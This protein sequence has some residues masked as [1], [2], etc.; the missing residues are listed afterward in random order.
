[1]SRY[2]IATGWWC[3]DDRDDRDCRKGDEIIRSREFHALWHECVTKYANA[4]EILVIDSASPIKP[5]KFPGEVWLEMKTN[6]GHATRCVEKLSGVSRAFLMSMMYC[7]LNEY[8]Y[9]V[10]VEQD[11]LIYG[12]GIIEK[13][14]EA[15]MTGM[16]FGSGKGTPQP[17]QHSLMVVN[18]RR[19]PAFIANYMSIAASDRDLSPEMKFAIAS[20]PFF[21]FLPQS[22]VVWAYTRRTPVSRLVKTLVG[23]LFQRFKGFQE[24]EFGCGRVR[25]ID[26]NA[27]FFYFQS[28]S[29]E[30][31][32]LFMRKTGLGKTPEAHLRPLK[33]VQV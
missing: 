7:C 32:A 25:P 15:D 24:L 17:L 8:D 33:K 31:L 20:S 12:E 9:W 4:E 1:M 27:E 23:A 29:Q 21:R 13:A 19:I 18:S 3:S 6:F 28:G 11:C 30:E 14:I 10:Y 22:V 2:L 5:P 16:V 26:F